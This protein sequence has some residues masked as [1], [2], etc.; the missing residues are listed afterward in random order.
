M[1]R[2]KLNQLE[3]LVVTVERGSFSGAAAELGC[4]QSRISH[5]IVELE[6]CIG[7]RLL[8]RSRSG[9]VPTLAGMKAFA[10]ARQMLEIADQIVATDA[11]EARLSGCVRLA[12]VRSVSNHVLPFVVEAMAR[13]LP[14][15]HVEIHDACNDYRE[16]TAMV[17]AGTADIG[18]T[19]APVGDDLV[20]RPFIEDDYVVIAPD[21]VR[22]ASP[23]CWTELAR[24]PLIRLQL[25][26]GNWIFEQCREQC[27]LAG[28]ELQASRALTDPRGIVALVAR[29]LGYSVLPQL[30][31]FPRTV[32][33]QILALPFPARRQLVV[34]AKP[35]VVRSRLITT[36]M[37][38]IV[39][40]RVIMKCEAWAC[41]AIGIGE[42]AS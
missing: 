32:G 1:T 20:A 13:D 24:L 11:G 26:G 6:R 14:D 17:Q 4:T 31:A 33:T 7:A 36:A 25:P 40:R 27:R 12:T 21:G 34:I 41:G 39:D 37:Q 5:G 35:G 3:M 19:R 9:C 22:L 16:V 23:V 8:D 30:V 18:I 42:P 2:V 28:L 29:G 38:R 15:V 10:H